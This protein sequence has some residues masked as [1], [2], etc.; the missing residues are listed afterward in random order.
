M[1]IQL[2]IFITKTKIF[3]SEINSSGKAEVI[4]INGNTEIKYEGK[5]SVDELITCLFDAFNIDDFAEDNFDIIILE[6]DADREVIKYLETK[7]TGAIKFN[8]ISVEKLLP[9]IASNKNLLKMDKEVTVTFANHFYKIF[10]A[11][12]NIVNVE[13]IAN[14]ESA[15]VLQE[16]D[17]ALLYRFVANP[18]AATDKSN[19]VKANAE[20]RAL[21]RQV[22]NYTKELAELRKIQKQ[23]VALQ[24]EQKKREELDKKEREEKNKQNNETK[25]ICPNCRNMLKADSNFCEVCGFQVFENKNAN[26][27]QV[28][29]QHKHIFDSS[30]E[31]QGEF[32]ISEA[33]P[34]NKI[35]S[36]MQ[37]SSNMYKIS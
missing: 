37:K 13:K 24:K 16:N 33:L 36:L 7:C 30:S 14:S 29:K 21:Q 25:K 9:V 8:I 23:F 10:C 31:Y 28:I 5:E 11:N 4:S 18:D 34:H 26:L 3:A 2:I 17:F 32:Y 15:I 35:R 22:D 20:I 1:P 19:L 6:S 12:S 27:M